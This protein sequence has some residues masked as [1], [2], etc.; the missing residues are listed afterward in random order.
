MFF[1]NV[2]F[3]YGVNFSSS[4][5]LSLH[6]LSL[7][8]ALSLFRSLAVPSRTLFLHSMNDVCESTRRNHLGSIVVLD[9]LRLELVSLVSKQET[10]ATSGAPRAKKST[11][12]QNDLY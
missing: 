1:Y 5:S 6:L 8:I 4:L 12:P 11:R 9:F 10:M 7:P 3:F 2:F